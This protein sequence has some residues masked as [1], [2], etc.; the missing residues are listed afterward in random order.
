MP[1]KKIAK[2]GINIR[3]N[4]EEA[5]KW[6]SKL[7]NIVVYTASHQSYADSVLN[8]IDP[9]KTYFYNRFY[10]NNCIDLV[11]NDS[12]IYVKDISIFENY[13][14][15]KDISIIDNSVLAF[16]FDLDNGIPILP[17]Y[18]AEQDIELL[19]CAYYL[20]SIADCDDLR[21]QHR[22]YLKME[23]YLEQAKK[24]VDNEKKERK[25]EQ[26]RARRK[27]KFNEDLFK[28]EEKDKEKEKDIEKE[29]NIIKD[30]GNEK[31]DF[32]KQFQFDLE[33]LRNTFSHDSCG[34]DW[35]CILHY[36]I[37]LYK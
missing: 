27:S 6:I 12:H 7:Y 9:N 10:R 16:A 37:N 20:E 31:K 23:Q 14:Q 13:F 36:K 25:R 5:I 15:L 8:F 21:I 19:F 1:S 29:K 3:P 24:E 35:W 17:Y 11:Y 22:K 28:K 32:C 30:N 26:N 34:S 33:C 18:D 4:W 2:I